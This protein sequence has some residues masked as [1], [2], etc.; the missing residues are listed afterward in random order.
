MLLL[1]V[2]VFGQGVVKG[3]VLDKQTNDVLQ[4]VNI[5]LTDAQSG[6]MV[7]GAITDSEGSFHLDDVP[8]GNYKLVI[9]YVGYKNATRNISLTNKNKSAHYTAIY[10]SEDQ[11]T[12]KEVK[13]TGQR[14]QMKLEVDRKTFTVDQVLAVL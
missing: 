9:S 11:Q 10:I 2:I 14:S 6:K 4:F 12:L 5:R 13:V 8:F 1:T 7:R 3:R